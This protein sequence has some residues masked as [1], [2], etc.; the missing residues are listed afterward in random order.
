M[1]P[2][3]FEFGPGIWAWYFGPNSG[4]FLFVCVGSLIVAEKKYET[5]ESSKRY[6]YGS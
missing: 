6:Y 4:L 2:F 3:V 1:G 5:E